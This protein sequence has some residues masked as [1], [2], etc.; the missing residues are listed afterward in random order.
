MEC[1]GKELG[2]QTCGSLGMD[3]HIGDCVCLTF[4]SGERCKLGLSH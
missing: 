4:E 3:H 1:L 2:W